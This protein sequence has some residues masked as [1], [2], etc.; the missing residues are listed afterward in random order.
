MKSSERCQNETALDEL[1]DSNASRNF[2]APIPLSGP[3]T[4]KHLGIPASFPSSRY[5]GLSYCCWS[6]VMSIFWS[7]FSLRHIRQKLR[8]TGASML[9]SSMSYCVTEN[10]FRWGCETRCHCWRAPS[11][12]VSDFI[13][14]SSLPQMQ[15]NQFSIDA[16]FQKRVIKKDP[17]LTSYTQRKREDG[18][19]KKNILF[20][21]A[22]C[23]G[24]V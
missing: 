9:A 19:K 3:M 7:N 23:A 15:K 14:C 5:F 13:S 8:R 11:R 1:T 16:W 21:L 17:R 24:K 2:W 6:Y 20:D 18:G 12:M 22:S 10:D 4:Q